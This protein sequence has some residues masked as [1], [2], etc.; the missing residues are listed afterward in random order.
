M[1]STINNDGPLDVNFAPLQDHYMDGLDMT[2][3]M[4]NMDN[5]L[6]F[7]T[8]DYGTDEMLRMMESEANMSIMDR[9]MARFEDS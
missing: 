6:A 4:D 9:F 1:C 7:T 8:E 2:Y 5:G 3:P